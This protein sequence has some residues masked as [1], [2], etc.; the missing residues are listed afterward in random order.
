M[1]QP[2][3]RSPHT[4][5]QLARRAGI[6]EGRARALATA[7]PSGLPRPDS[8]DADGRPLWWAATIDAW[9]ARTGRKISQDSLWLFRAPAAAGP[10]PELRRGI[11]TL[12]GPYR[13]RVFYAIVWDTEHGHV[14][15]LQP[16]DDT[17]GDHG[18]WGQSRADE[19]GWLGPAAQHQPGHD[20]RRADPHHRLDLG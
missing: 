16:L 12:A 13:Q 7:T 15:Y 19:G 6:S 10:A 18:G 2:S 4:L 1:G 9:C 8:A 17:G 14:I 3:D 11:V 5:A 20:L